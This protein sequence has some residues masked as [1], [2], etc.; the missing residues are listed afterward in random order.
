MSYKKSGIIISVVILVIV[1]IL[2][3]TFG[4]EV[5]NTGQPDN[6]LTPNSLSSDNIKPESSQN[7]SSSPKSEV[8]SVEETKSG[9]TSVGEAP[10]EVV[11]ESSREVSKEA[12]SSKESESKLSS[13]VESSNVSSNS[14]AKKSLDSALSLQNK[15][16]SNE[17]IELDPKTVKN[18]A[19]AK[20]ITGLVSSK[21]MYFYNKQVY[22]QFE[23]ITADGKYYSY[24]VPEQAYTSISVQSSVKLTVREYTVKDE[25]VTCVLSVETVQ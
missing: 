20:T 9:V 16:F 7:Q 22:H 23:I 14:D 25:V 6:G 10:K 17:M 11:K 13:G 5:K 3:C 12:T 15:G 8:T 1:I 24:F 2:Y 19:K 18:G 4:I 21:H